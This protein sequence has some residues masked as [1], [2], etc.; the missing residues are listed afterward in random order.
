MPSVARDF[1]AI[2][3]DNKGYVT[4]DQIRDH[5]KAAR[6]ARREARR[7]AAKTQ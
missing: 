7:A 4:I 1:T 6:A 5:A 2:D 3:T